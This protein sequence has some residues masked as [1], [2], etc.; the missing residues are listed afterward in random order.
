MT[1]LYLTTYTAIA[2]NVSAAALA[3]ALAAI[4]RDTQTETLLGLV[5]LTDTTTTSGRFVTRSLSY[6]GSPGSLIPDPQ[7]GQFLVNMYTTLF[8]SGLG[9]PVVQ[10]GVSIVVVPSLPVLWVRADAGAPGLAVTDWTDLSGNGN[11]LVQASGPEQPGLIVTD[12]LLAVLFSGGQ[13]MATAGPLAFDAFSYFVTFKTPLLSTPGM[14]FERGINATTNSGENLFQSQ[15]P[16][17]SVVA[18]RAGVV[19]DT[20]LAANWGIAGVWQFAQYTYGRPDGGAAAF[21][22]QGGGGGSGGFAALAAEAV[23]APLFVGARSGLSL[24]M[25]GAVRELMVFDSELSAAAISPIA[26][27]MQAQVGI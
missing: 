20:D 24:P 8:A 11:D 21:D 7:L 13:I 15:A 6:S 22:D 5:N 17:H 26:L 2:R 23:S 1:T 27:Y 25:V 9:A 18:R 4:P 19:H 14:L 12:D 3:N 16:A 10:S